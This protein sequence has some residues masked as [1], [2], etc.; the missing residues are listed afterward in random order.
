MTRH[1]RSKE[2]TRSCG[3]LLRKVREGAGFS[4]AQIG[5]K[6][7]RPKEFL[8]RIERGERR[9]EVVDFMD[10]CAAAG[11]DAA[12]AL[13]ELFAESAHLFEVDR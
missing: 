12:E 11:K 3:T 8:D 9:I 1:E 6:C 5:R 2:I 7:D 10:I 4:R 13:G